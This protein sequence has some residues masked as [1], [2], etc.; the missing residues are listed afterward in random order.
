[1]KIGILLAD[2]TREE[3]IEKHGDYD[4]LFISLLADERFD[5][6]TYAV[7]DGIFP[8]DIFVA[9]GWLITGARFA[10]YESHVWIPPLERLIRAI[11]AARLPMIG[12]CFGHQIIAQA[13]GGRVEKSGA[14]WTAGPVQYERKDLRK[15][16][17]VLAWHQDEVVI[18]PDGAETIGSSAHCE[19]AIL[20][21]GSALVTY[22]GHPELNAEYL[23]GLLRA[24][25]SKFSEEAAKNVLASNDDDL[26]TEDFVREMK[27]LYLK[28]WA[29]Q[30]YPGTS[31]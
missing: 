23:F 10:V 25:E 8:K 20:R 7:V 6:E 16:Q 26:D 24:G 30:R 12:V 22:Q 2:H 15:T 14:G 5:F 19:N 3:M 11:Y 1:M 18:K 27:S 28:G 9:D 4:A 29:G 21:Y 17:R 13:L 31:G